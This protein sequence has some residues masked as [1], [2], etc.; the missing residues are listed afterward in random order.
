MP[1]YRFKCRNHRC[2]SE[3]HRYYPSEEFDHHQYGTANGWA[4]F[5]CGF[6]KMAVIKSNKRA[7]DSFKP[8]FQRN[9]RKYCS[10]YSEYKQY[11]KNNGLVEIGYDEIKED[12]NGRFN[13]WDDQML[14]KVYDMAQLSGRE[15]EALKNGE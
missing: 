5:N 10:T 6:P 7:K 3:F 15:L 11:L 13:Y 9:I 14:K 12:E 4:C 8:G 2:G 1:S